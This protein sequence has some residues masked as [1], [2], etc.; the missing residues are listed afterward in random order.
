MTDVTSAGGSA[1]VPAPRNE[2]HSSSP[3]AG[4]APVSDKASPGTPAPA[5]SGV[6]TDATPKA[7]PNPQETKMETEEV[8]PTY[9]IMDWLKEVFTPPEIWSAGNRPLKDEWDYAMNGGW[10]TE[11]GLIRFF[12]QVYSLLVVFPIYAVTE[13]VQWA[14]KRPTRLAMIVVLFTLLAQ[15]PPMNALGLF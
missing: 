3:S 7:S 12:G 8:T 2:V 14:V 10:T 9:G 6:H 4:N 15:I 1:H 13:F 5:Y 11:D